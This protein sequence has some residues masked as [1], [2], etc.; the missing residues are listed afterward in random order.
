MNN[1]EVTEQALRIL[2]SG[3]NF[4]WTFITLFVLVVYVYYNEIEHKNW[5]KIAAGL[6][7]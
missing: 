5:N 3:E 7:A 6:F 2:R 4:H 1:P